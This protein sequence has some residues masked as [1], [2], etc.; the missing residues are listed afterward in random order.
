VFAKLKEFVPQVGF[1]YEGGADAVAA[2]AQKEVLVANYYMEYALQSDLYD[3][4]VR[5]VV[6]KEGGTGYL[7]YF[8]VVR[9]TRERDLAERFIDFAAGAQQETAFT[10]LQMTQP[11]NRL[12]Q[13]PERGRPFYASTD[14]GWEKQIAN[15]VD[16][17]C[18]GQDFEKVHD[19]YLR[20]ILQGSEGGQ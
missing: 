10:A 3:L 13:I 19:R 5:A 16:Y 20:E 9:G 18:F 14:A 8:M 17:A 11:A 1:W 6:P 15:I 12:A 2:L 7:D 4:G